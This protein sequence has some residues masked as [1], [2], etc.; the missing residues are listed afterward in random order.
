LVSGINIRNSVCD[1]VIKRNKASF[2]IKSDPSPLN[3][4][5]E[6]IVELQRLVSLGLNDPVHPKEI[7]AWTDDRRGFDRVKVE[8]RQALSQYHDEEPSAHHYHFTSAETNLETVLEK[9]FDDLNGGKIL[10][11]LYFGTTYNDG[12]FEENR[13]LSLVSAMESYHD[14]VLF[15]KD[16]SI[17]E[18]EFEDIKDEVHELV[19]G[20]GLENRMNGLIKHVINDVSIKDK[21]SKF[22]MEYEYIY[23]SLSDDDDYDHTEVINEV[24][25]EAAGAR[26]AIAHGSA[27]LDRDIIGIGGAADWLQLGIEACLLT[28]VGIDQDRIADQ[29]RINY[30]LRLDEVTPP[31]VDIPESIDE[32]S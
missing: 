14:R 6:Y 10:R 18:S 7:V 20:T 13:L 31:P 19:S 22:M 27:D 9:W 28:V 26:H 11:N 2:L 30:D 21:I 15:P 25:K 23:G 32:P 12:M 17:P 1:K 4:F 16:T 3:Y 29:L 5:D 24:A 8:V